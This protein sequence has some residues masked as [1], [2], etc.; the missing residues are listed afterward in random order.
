M[1]DLIKFKKD[2]INNEKTLIEI[3][4]GI[5]KDCNIA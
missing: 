4:K 2:F 3:R 5:T 1:H